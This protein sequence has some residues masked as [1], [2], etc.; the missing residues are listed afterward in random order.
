MGTTRLQGEGTAIT[1]LR[2]APECRAGSR[3]I[4]MIVMTTSRTG[5]PG[6][7][8]SSDSDDELAKHRKEL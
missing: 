6:T 5:T 4:E 2:L 3:K 1:G 7:R 8:T